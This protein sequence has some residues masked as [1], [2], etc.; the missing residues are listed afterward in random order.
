MKFIHEESLVNVFKGL[1][2]MFKYHE[3]PTVHFPSFYFILFFLE[4][5]F[6]ALFSTIIVDKIAKT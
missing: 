4:I 3:L 2:A 1:L 5:Y 6:D